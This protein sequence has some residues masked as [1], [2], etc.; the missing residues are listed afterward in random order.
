MT[1]KK[2]MSLLYSNTALLWTAAMEQSGSTPSIRKQSDYWNSMVDSYEEDAQV[3]K[4]K[5][6]FCVEKLLSSGILNN[7]SSLLEVGPA[8][9]DLALMLS[10]HIPN[11][12]CCDISENMLTKLKQKCEY[13]GINNIDTICQN[14]MEIKDKKFDIAGACYVP[15]TF[16]EK[17]LFKLVELGKSGGFLMCSCEGISKGSTVYR[18]LGLLL[19]EKDQT[20]KNDII[21][22][23]NLLY[24][25]G[26]FP[27]I[28]YYRKSSSVSWDEKT[29]I[30]KLKAY[31]ENSV[32]LPDNNDQIIT[33]YVKSNIHDGSL[34]MESDSVSALI[35]WRCK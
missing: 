5:A 4:E 2:E 8:T 35:I 20:L 33:D 7:R 14:F 22:P 15:S 32:G 23:F 28:F 10:R 17:G 29:A 11:I 25:K 19:F 24:A 13:V 12:T 31:F 21:Y 1:Q 18:E 34:I 30:S 16:N 6:N 9:G 26:L 27:E 3:H